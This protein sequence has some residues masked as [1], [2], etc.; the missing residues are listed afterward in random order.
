M[1][2]IL[3]CLL[4]LSFS[5]NATTYF[6]STSGSNGNNGQSQAAPFQTVNAAVSAV[7]AGDSISLKRGDVFPCDYY[8]PTNNIKWGA[9]GTGANPV[10]SGFVTVGSWVNE[11]GGFYSYTD[12][13]LPAFLNVVSV[14][15]AFQPKRTSFT[16]STFQAHTGTGTGT[17][18]DNTL[19]GSPSLV[20]G[21]LVIRKRR[22][23]TDR[24][25]IT[26]H[27]GGTLTYGNITG[28]STALAYTPFD[29]YGYFVQNH[30]SV[31]TTIG[32][33]KYDGSGK[34]ITMYFGGAS[35][36][37]YVVRLSKT[38]RFAGLDGTGNTFTGIDFTG[39]NQYG[40]SQ[41]GNN[42]SMINCNFSFIG[43]GAIYVTNRTGITFTGCTFTDMPNNGLSGDTGCDNWA[44]T[45]CTFTRIGN[46]PGMGGSNDNKYIASYIS[47]ANMIAEG[48]T[49]T[50]VGLYGIY[51][52]GDGC[53]VRKN[54]IQNYCKV[55]DDGGGIYTFEGN[56]VSN[57]T[58]RIVED[59]IIINGVGVSAGSAEGG[60]LAHGIYLDEKSSQITVRRNTIIGANS[61]IFLHNASN[62]ILKKN[63]IVGTQKGIKY[64][65]YDSGDPLT[66]VA[67][68]SNIIAITAGNYINQFSSSQSTLAG[69]I[70]STNNR[71]VATDSTGN[72]FSTAINSGGG[73][74]SPIT[75]AAW[76]SITGADATSYFK[77]APTYRIEYN[78][79]SSPVGVSL[80]GNLYQDV[81]GNNYSGSAN[82]P[83]YGSILLLNAG[84]VVTVPGSGI[85]IKRKVR[86]Q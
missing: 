63:T 82:V 28:H 13:G 84:A 23:V 19:S 65:T 42:L 36:S 5:A 12:A 21:E 45:G 61:G 46:W 38:Y 9:Y 24:A 4:G 75:F 69:K 62:N 72:I 11:G 81:Y 35:P 80:S 32:D 60:L 14:N 33:W 48:N 17:I 40:F 49:V 39:L 79:T 15:G 77:N 30:S 78:A 44:V 66:G 37:S 20:G 70:T 1:R 18:T 54:L 85:L 86:T 55:K 25:S 52:R 58:G 53:I 29:G 2:I 51:F 76:K 83:A 7:V 57:T 74:E 59:N 10:F 31:M 71:Y 3:L 73:D 22:W 16:Y 8:L 41:A 6:V 50:D 68:D 26:A 67:A 27:S 34:K 56:V 47:G 43:E 64:R